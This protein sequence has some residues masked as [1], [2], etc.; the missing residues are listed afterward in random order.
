[1]I[2][3]HHARGTAGGVPV[4]ERR[5]RLRE[6]RTVL[7]VEWG[8]RGRMFGGLT[9]HRS[10]TYER[11]RSRPRQAMNGH[12][13]HRVQWGGRACCGDIPL[14]VTVGVRVM[15]RGIKYA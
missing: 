5:E 13:D 11:L 7:E 14:E 1:M 4:S 2:D 8:T 9:I 15:M 12:R 3:A 10:A 6:E